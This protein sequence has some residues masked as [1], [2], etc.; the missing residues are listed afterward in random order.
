MPLP[1][2]R[3]RA[4]RPALTSPASP[5]ADSTLVKAIVVTVSANTR[6]AHVGADPRWIGSSSVCGLK[7][8]A[9]PRIMMSSCSERSPAASSPMRRALRPPLK[10]RTLMSTTKA[11]KASARSSDSA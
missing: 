11:M 6:F 2:S 4:P 5:E 10:P 7:N 1:T 8:S 3:R 9:S